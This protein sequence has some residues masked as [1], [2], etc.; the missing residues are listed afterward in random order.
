MSDKSM[1]EKDI[2]IVNELDKWMKSNKQNTVTNI[3]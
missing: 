1:N 2:Q 3:I